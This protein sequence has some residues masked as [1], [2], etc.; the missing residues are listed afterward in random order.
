MKT[1]IELQ[2][3][4]FELSAKL[5][6]TGAFAPKE[7]ANEYSVGNRRNKFKI[8][9]RVGKAY[10]SFVYYDCISNYEKG[11]KTI[12]VM[13]AFECFVNDAISGSDS[14]YNFCNDIGYDEDSRRAEKIWKACKM[15]LTKLKRLFNGDI[16]DLYDEIQ[17]R[18]TLKSN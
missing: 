12:D 4:K 1:T 16:Y 2:G 10:T 13:E 8:T 14:F 18:E 7:W 6:E 17:Q 9:V 5:I 15:S 11:V 3:T